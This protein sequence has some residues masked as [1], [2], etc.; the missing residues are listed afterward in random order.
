MTVELGVRERKKL[1]ARTALTSAA[2]SLFQRNGFDATTVNDIAHLAGMSPRTFFRYFDTKEDVVF[3]DAPRH[4]EAL[5]SYLR[6]R[7]ESETNGA[8]LRAALLSF[9]EML[10]VERDEI[11]LRA[12]LASSARTLAE[13]AAIEVQNW[14]LALAEELMRRPGDPDATGC[15]LLAGAGINVLTVAIMLRSNGDRKLP[16]LTEYC[17]QQLA[18]ALCTS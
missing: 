9:A 16:E 14:S 2:L 4:L 13:R 17:Y 12:Q 10:E 7:P 5:R 15:H 8:A 6:D 1:A 18:A 11:Q 3:Q